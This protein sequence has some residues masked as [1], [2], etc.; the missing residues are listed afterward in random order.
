MEFPG[1]DPMFLRLFV[2]RNLTAALIGVAIAG[3]LPSAFAQRI[4]TCK[5]ANGK[6]ITSDRPLPECQGREGRELSK[7]GTTLRTIEGALTPEQIAAREKEA[8]KKR[9]EDELRKDQLRRD[10]ALLNTYA[11]LDDI[12]SKR[13]RALSQVE[14]E[15][16]EAE[17]RISTLERQAGENRAEADFYRK[18]QLP[19]NLKRKQD[20]NEAALIAERLLFTSKKSEV[21]QVNLKFDQD[22]KRYIELTGADKAARK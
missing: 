8:Q 14:R 1:A 2:W 15:A 13:Q 9:D 5:D 18:K 4:Y 19:A 6:T 16:R 22:R 11:N 7:Q 12:E 3:G 21:T 10:K 17:R 20:E